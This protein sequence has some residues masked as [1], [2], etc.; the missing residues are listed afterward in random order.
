MCKSLLMVFFIIPILKNCL[1]L[2]NL[3]KN[4][5]KEPKIFFWEGGTLFPEKTIEY[6]EHFVPYTMRIFFIHIQFKNIY[7]FKFNCQY[8]RKKTTWKMPGHIFSC[9]L[10]SVNNRFLIIKKLHSELNHLHL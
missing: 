2:R 7:I 10:N 1:N 8:F 5:N 3:T 6:F 9:K 4:V